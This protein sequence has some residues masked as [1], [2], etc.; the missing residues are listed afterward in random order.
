M[1]G[2]QFG[3]LPQPVARAFDLHHHSMVKKAIQKGR[4]HNS[5]SKNLAPFRKSA[6]GGQDHGAF[7]IAG[8][9]QLED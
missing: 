8:I 1:L 5:V 2:H 3:V 4:G 7:F 6:I 9:D